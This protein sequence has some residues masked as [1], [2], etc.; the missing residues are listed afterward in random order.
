[1]NKF[2]VVIFPNE[3]RA[4][5]GAEVLRDLHADGTLTLYGLAVGRKAADGDV[6]VIEKEGEGL[7]GA[8]VGALAGA[9]VGLLGGPLTAAV[10]AAGGAW[11]GTWRDIAHLGVG[12]DFLAEVG[13]E[14]TPGTTALVADVSED[15]VSP[16]DEQMELLDGT[17]LREWQS[18]LPEVQLATEAA[19]RKAE[20]EHLE[21][22]RREASQ[23]RRH[24]L[25]IRVDKAEAKL[26]N[27]GHRATKKLDSLD[28]ATGSKIEAL[29]HQAA[30]ADTNAR[31]SIERRIAETRADRDRRAALL[32][33]TLQV[34]S[35]AR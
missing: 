9:L 35:D 5:E 13:R 29:K 12:A 16:L 19:A 1:M 31:A 6:S 21:A 7:P 34:A 4:N 27:V 20:L 30:T 33:Q 32:R 26:E 25:D 8:A 15:R 18:E 23:Q 3:K 14:L 28:Q 17:V 22:E 2:V 10:G 11:I 24:L